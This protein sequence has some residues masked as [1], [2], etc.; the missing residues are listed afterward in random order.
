MESLQLAHK[1][2]LNSFYGYVMRKGS[3]WYSMEMAGIVTYLGATLIQMARALV[4][5]IGI[6]LELDTD[7]IWCCLPQSFPENFTFT[8]NNPSSSKVTISY[9]CVVLNKMV[10]DDYTNHQYQTCISPGVYE[11]RSECSIYFEVDGPYLAMMLPASR[12]EG[13]SIKKR[14]AVFDPDGRL[15]DLKGFELKRRGELMLIKDFQSQVFRRF[16]D[17]TTLVEAYESASVVANVALDMLYS[18]GEGYEADEILEKLSESSNMTRR[19]SEYPESQKSLA[20]TTARRIADFLGPQMVKDKGL[21]CQFVI[22]RLPSGRPVTERAIPLTI[23]RADPTVRTHFLRKWT[24]DNTLSANIDLQH[25]LDW[26]YYIARYSACVQKIITIP[27]A[28]QHVPNPVPRVPYPEWLQKRV[29]QR[30]SRFKQ[31]SLTGM[32]EKMKSNEGDIPDV[33]DLVNNSD[34]T[35]LH[36][37]VGGDLQRN[38]ATSGVDHSAYDVEEKSDN[39]SSSDSA[40]GSHDGHDRLLD[41]AMA[42][43]DGV[44]NALKDKYFAPGSTHSLD[45]DFFN[46]PGVDAWLTRQK[47]AWIHRAKLRR[48]VMKEDVFLNADGK[49][50][51]THFIDV[52]AKSLSATWQIIE[53]RPER[54]DSDTVSVIAVLDKTLYT[55]QCIV[56]RR[57]I[58]DADPVADIPCASPVTTA[59]VLPR[60]RTPVKLLHV[61][62]PPGQKGERMLNE[63]RKGR[64]DVYAVYEDNVTRT[65]I[66][67]ERVGCCANVIVDDHL[68]NARRRPH[69]RGTFSVDELESVSAANYMQNFSDRF[70]FIFHVTSDT[71]GI[72]GVVNHYNHTALIVVVQPSSAPVPLLDWKSLMIEAAKSVNSAECSLGIVQEVTADTDSAWR[73]IHRAL[74]EMLEGVG[75]PLLAVLESNITT[76]QLLEQRY[77]P[78]VLP[79]LRV[80]GAAEDERLLSDPFRWVKL[81]GRRLL[82]RYCSSPQWIEERVAFSR[83]SKIPICNLK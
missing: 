81:L 9:P 30:S 56:T 70:V 39:Q 18:K 23:F 3:R 27:A 14:Y 47:Q 44:V 58:V 77:L 31:I 16:L 40:A 12:E 63:L 13:K 67:V 19:L 74:N 35:R 51:S 60:N 57:I 26:D 43:E 76:Q 5:Q 79:Y 49:L 28:L 7:G 42:L 17:G 25:L 72:V 15:A 55:F 71:R 52:R 33:E 37:G 8:T 80:L 36:R 73:L 38:G 54:A 69:L 6:T 20:L 66:M 48:E 2:I 65:E 75:S 59:H 78:P 64:E 10:H 41:Q 11:R 50:A 46:N 62:L 34:N 32:F 61:D 83:L 53:I 24:G 21:A 45:A 22:S 1:C 82:Q 29:Q 68:R 4:Q